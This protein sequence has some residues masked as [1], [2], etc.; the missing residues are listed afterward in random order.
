MLLPIIHSDKYDSKDFTD[1]P[2]VDAVTT[3]DEEK[4]TLTLFAVNRSMTESVTLD[5]E[6]RDFPGYKVVEH[7]FMTDADRNAVNT[8]TC[9]AR[10]VPRTDGK[11]VLSG[12]VLVS[13]LPSF[14][15]NVVR[16]QKKHE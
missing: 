2:Y 12:T 3:W 1:V 14:S 13:V 16:L 6:L 8:N 4:E 11:S 7:I 5:T 10:V 15:W 9:P